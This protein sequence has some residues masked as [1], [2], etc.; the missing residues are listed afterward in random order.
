MLLSK[1]IKKQ[2]W[3]TLSFLN[4]TAARPQKPFLTI[5]PTTTIREETVGLVI[6]DQ[7][8]KAGSALHRVV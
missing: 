8:F 1:P 7:K 4:A 5:H 6:Y 2:R 3:Y